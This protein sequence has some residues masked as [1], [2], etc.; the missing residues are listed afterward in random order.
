MSFLI[1]KQTPQFGSR[2]TDT[3]KSMGIR[4]KT[5]LEGINEKDYGNETI[6]KG[7]R[8]IKGSRTRQGENAFKTL[9]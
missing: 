3:Q 6:T 1:W 9:G 5:D 4:G 7:I 2:I 8:I